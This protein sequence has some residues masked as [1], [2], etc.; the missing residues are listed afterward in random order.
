MMPVRGTSSHTTSSSTRIE[1]RTAAGDGRMVFLE[2]G[3]TPC[4]IVGCFI[5]TLAARGLTPSP[6]AHWSFLRPPVVALNLADADEVVAIPDLS[7]L[8]LGDHVLGVSG[9]CRDGFEILP[10]DDSDAGSIGISCRL[11]AQI[12]LV[13]LGALDHSFVHLGML[14]MIDLGVDRRKKNGVVGRLWRF[15]DEGHDCIPFCF[16]VSTLRA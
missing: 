5:S 15:A 7:S 8:S 2:W 12:A 13:G 11:D 16:E 10:V 6:L 9:K 3:Q 4:T 14:G 1:R